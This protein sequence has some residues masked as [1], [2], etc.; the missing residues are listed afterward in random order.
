MNRLGWV[1]WLLCCVDSTVTFA[2]PMLMCTRMK[3][4]WG[5]QY[6][7]AVVV[8]GLAR[9]R[10]GDQNY[11]NVKKNAWPSSMG[12]TAVSR[13]AKSAQSSYMPVGQESKQI[14][15][16]K[17]AT[18]SLPFLPLGLFSLSN[19][20]CFHAFETLDSFF[21]S[22]LDGFLATIIETRHTLLAN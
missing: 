5:E 7:V 1:N 16:V 9:L 4:E 10:I 15:S 12:N 8:N 6:T 13:T 18:Q 20:S 19:A 21:R 3:S 17:V 11:A 2:C 22:T 14:V